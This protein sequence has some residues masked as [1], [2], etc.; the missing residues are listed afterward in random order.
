MPTTSFEKGTTMKPT[1]F[2]MYLIGGVLAGY[3]LGSA[4]LAA[5]AGPSSRGGGFSSGRSYSAPVRPTPRSQAVTPQRPTT[6]APKQESPQVLRTERTIV[7]E[8][9]Q[10][11]SWFSSPLLWGIFSYWLGSQ[12]S[13]QAGTTSLP[14]LTKQHEKLEIISPYQLVDTQ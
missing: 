4:I 8:R 9:P 10:S 6:S 14:E 1:D 12:S 13:P 3:L 11:S 7:V 5:K 2:F